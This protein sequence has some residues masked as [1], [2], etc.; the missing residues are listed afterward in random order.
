M[1]TKFIDINK[2][3]KVEMLTESEKQEIITKLQAVTGEHWENLMA[4]YFISDTGKVYSATRNKLITP[5]LNERDGYLTFV[6]SYQGKHHTFYVHRVV[7]LLFNNDIGYN[8][9][10]IYL[11]VYGTYATHHID[12]DKTNNKANNLIWIKQ[13]TH[14]TLHAMLNRGEI[15]QSDINT[16][17]KLISVCGQIVRARQAKD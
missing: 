3:T 15:K 4:T 16:I 7:N 17:G 10:D 1:T 14:A 6:I 12:G 11:G 9:I 5:A 8:P 13:G 2:H